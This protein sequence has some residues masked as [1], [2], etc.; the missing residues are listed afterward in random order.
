MA[1][2]HE[3][4]VG[5]S[6]FGPRRRIRPWVWIKRN[7]WALLIGLV[8]IGALIWIIWPKS[9]ET[10]LGGR[11]AGAPIAVNTAKV[12]TGDVQV[13]LNALGTVT[14]LATVTVRTQISGQL[15][16]IAFTEGQTV[17]KGDFLAE[18]D[19]RPYQAALEQA[20]GTLAKDQALLT[21]AQLD[22]ERYKKLVAED[23]IAH[24]Q[25]DTQLAL[26]RQYQGT[27]L[28]DQAAVD[29]ATLNL[30]YCHIVSPVTGRVGL[31]QVDQGNYVTPGDTNGIVVVTQLQPI[32]ALF[33]LPED[34]VLKVS[35]P[36][37]DGQTL[38]VTAMDRGNT[39]KLA[40]GALTNIDNQIDTTTGTFKLRAQ[41]TN[42][43]E[44]L[45]PNQ[46]VNVQ[47][48]VETLRDQMV[49]PTAAIQRG[50]P[51]TFVYAVNPDST[52]SVR[53]VKLGIAQGERQAILTGIDAGETIVTDGVDRLRD[54][55]KVVLPGA[56]PPAPG[57]A[58]AEGGRRHRRN[59]ANGSGQG[60]TD[61]GKASGDAKPSGGP[62]GNSAGGR[63]ATQ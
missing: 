44:S 37:H 11:G 2:T 55:A 43:D 17:K 60:G 10:P 7:K 54:G 31:R 40:T 19:P 52:V 29:N 41:F 5:D 6:R 46:F 12:E 34:N 14:P 30:N 36:L 32:S 51:G 48:L 53:P 27:V 56:Q 57:A 38:T 39:T 62:N 42:A 26:V 21:N 58:S 4:T 20:Q 24:Q 1:S 61:D 45:F 35:K 49:V 33:T 28:T 13:I 8:V 47:L 15:Q 18:V 3:T 9:V 25:L 63:P 22:A 23:S 16:Q 59:G 50:A